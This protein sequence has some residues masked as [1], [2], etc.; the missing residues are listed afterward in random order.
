M[1]ITFA[2]LAL[3]ACSF[4]TT[5]AT[6]R[7]AAFQAAADR[8]ALPESWLLAIGYQ[9]GRFEPAEA[10]DTT[11]D[12]DAADATDT[13]DTLA[14]DTPADDV[15]AAPDD[16]AD[17]ADT[18]PDT[19]A[20]G[21]MYLTDAQVARAAELTGRDPDELRTSNAANIEGA[22][23][24][25][26]D[27]GSD[28]R[29]ATTAFLGV[30]DD[31]ADLALDD[32]DSIVEAGFDV[33]TEDGEHL[34]LPGTD[35]IRADITEAM[36][37]EA[38]AG[39]IDRAGAYPHVQWI[40]SPN[41]SSRLGSPIRYIVIHDMEGT[42]PAAI[43]IFRKASSQVSAHYL[44]RSRDGHIVKMVHETDD[45]WHAGHG[46]FNRHSIGIEHEGFANRKR[47]GGYYTDTLYEASAR[48]TCA[49][50]H[51][52]GIPVDRKHIFGHLNVPSSLSSHTLCSDKRGIAGA[53]GGVSHHTDPGRYWNWTKYMHLVATCVHDA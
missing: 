15:E 19:R 4:Q 14:A 47:G 51:R 28:L 27:G 34:T 29:A 24:L 2:L 1:R 5:D 23:A 45:A 48:L 44:V 42:M 16:S 43:S 41:F 39:M 25:L 22:A 46:W 38:S 12:T 53:C 3:T 8:Y 26:A 52:Y 31:A 10:V 18:G 21:V 33:T 11:P 30:S 6:T 50:A 32:L 49:I 9:Q 7:T 13:A 37:D 40:R 20:W 17:A 36:D 35:P